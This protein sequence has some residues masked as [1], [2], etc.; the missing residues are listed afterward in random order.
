MKYFLWF[1]SIF[2]LISCNPTE[3]SEKKHQETTKEENK[4]EID[5]IIT[6]KNLWSI[7]TDTIQVI[8]DFRK[9][10]VDSLTRTIIKK[11]KSD[12]L[13]YCFAYKFNENTVVTIVEDEVE[14]ISYSLFVINNYKL[15]GKLIVA[16]STTWEHGNTETKSIISNDSLI[17]KIKVTASKDW[18]D[19]S[20]W[21]RDT[22]IEKYLINAN[23]EIIEIK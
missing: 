5:S 15:T 8:P 22:I 13:Y 7:P 23:G 11:R 2:I 16:E 18:G 12:D 10:A 4:S 21:K 20:Q 19:Y 3:E 9:T 14:Y 1:F 6:S 17:T